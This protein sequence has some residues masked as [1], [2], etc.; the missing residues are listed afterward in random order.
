MLP[1][2]PKAVVR[3]GLVYNLYK[4]GSCAPAQ[5]P[6]ASAQP[7]QSRPTVRQS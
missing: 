7:T 4:G 6:T 2:G 5:G 3:R 1:V